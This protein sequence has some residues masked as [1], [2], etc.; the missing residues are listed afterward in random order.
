MGEIL[1]VVEH[2]KGE[3]REITREM[4]F[5]AGELC[6]AASHELVAVVLVDGEADRMGQ[7]VAKMAD[8]VLVFKDPRFENFDSHLYGE[9]L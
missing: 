7:E 4:L 8:K 6:T 3:I 9:V 5:K 2:R 1:V